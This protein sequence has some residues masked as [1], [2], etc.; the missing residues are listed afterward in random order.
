MSLGCV[1]AT[2]VLYQ[3]EFPPIASPGQWN[4]HPFVDKRPKPRTVCFPFS[5]VTAIDVR[6]T[7]QK[8]AQY[9]SKPDSVQVH[10]VCCK[11]RSRC[12][13]V[14]W[15]LRAHIPL[16]A[17]SVVS[18]SSSRLRC[19]RKGTCYRLKEG[20]RGQRVFRWLALFA[21]P[22]IRTSRCRERGKH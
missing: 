21:Q 10:W 3:A 15:T 12:H 22:G 13:G 17:V 4:L 16:H 5:L 9:L 19:W 11:D 20:E 2:Y 14:H 6:R 7:D 1:P 8:P 18:V